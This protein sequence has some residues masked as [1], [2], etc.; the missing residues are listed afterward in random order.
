MAEIVEEDINQSTSGS[1]SSEIDKYDDKKNLVEITLKTIGPSPPSRLLVPS[2]IKV[3]DL[4]KLISENNHLPIEKLRL[5]LRGKVLHDSRDE[6][7]I[8]IQLK[9]SDS[10]IVAV[11]PNPPAKH[12]RDG[13][14]DDDDLKFQLPQ[15]TSRWKRRLYFFL[16]DKLKLPGILLMA[17]FSL[18]LKVWILIILWFILAPVAHRWDLGPL[19]LLPD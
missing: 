6:D 8:Q 13:F 1:T 2:R 11:K 19:Y 12:L 16:H 14:D 17:L 10:L 7:D 15:S 18:S 4:R 3:H 5:I 9:N